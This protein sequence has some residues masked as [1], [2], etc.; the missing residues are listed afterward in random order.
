MTTLQSRVGL[1][2]VAAAIPG[3][4]TT[5][6]IASISGAEHSIALFIFCA[7]P[8]MIG[9]H[10]SMSRITAETYQ[11]AAR[12]QAW[13]AGRPAR[14][15]AAAAA[16]RDPEAVAAAER[17]AAAEHTAVAERAAAAEHT[18]DQA[19]FDDLVRD[20]HQKLGDE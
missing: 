2:V 18:A 15:A 14:E 3:L 5:A 10:I 11:K 16:E 6:V 17:A 12:K 20:A 8:W 1:S 7:A 13:E 9:I 19:L 4:F